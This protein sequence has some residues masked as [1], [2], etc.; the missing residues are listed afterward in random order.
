MGKKMNRTGHGDG[1]FYNLGSQ[2]SLKGIPPP[3][4]EEDKI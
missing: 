3:T 4:L 1:G 2:K